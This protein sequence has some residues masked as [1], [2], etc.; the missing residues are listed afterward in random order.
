M[1]FSIIFDLI[2]RPERQKLVIW[3]QYHSLAY[4]EYNFVPRDSLTDYQYPFDYLGD[5][6]YTNFHLLFSKL[7]NMGYYIEVLRNCFLCFDPME[8]GTLMLVDTEDVFLELE[9][10]KL[11]EDIVMNGL[12]LFLVAD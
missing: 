1:F 9:I 6:I 5:S 12:N 8:Y 2:K 10:K 7:R 11:E 4:P 3:D